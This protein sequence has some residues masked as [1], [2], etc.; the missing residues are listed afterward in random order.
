MRGTRGGR[1]HA[2]PSVLP[3]P[4]AA[5]QV[6]PGGRPPAALARRRRNLMQ[7]HREH[8]PL[9][10]SSVG[11]VLALFPHTLHHEVAALAAD[12]PHV[13]DVSPGVEV[14]GVTAAA[15]LTGPQVSARS[16]CSGNNA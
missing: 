11:A 16:E 5:S 7:P 4:P 8:T 2:R 9:L 1:V 12:Q 6:R 3:A 13:P 15:C 10:V 14:Q